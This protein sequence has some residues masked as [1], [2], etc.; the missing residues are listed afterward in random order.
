MVSATLLWTSCANS[1]RTQVPDAVWQSTFNPAKPTSLVEDVLELTVPS[2]IIKD[3]LEGE[4]F[5]V[6]RNALASSNATHITL[7]ICTDQ[8]SNGEDSSSATLSTTN[9]CSRSR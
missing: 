1:I 5:E 3:R 8:Q 9:L 6:L 4:Y 2:T 7:K